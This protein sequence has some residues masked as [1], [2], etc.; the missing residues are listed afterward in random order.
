[1]TTPKHKSRA[2]RAVQKLKYELYIHI[3]TPQAENDNKNDY[4]QTHKE[5]SSSFKQMSS[6]VLHLFLFVCFFVFMDTLGH[7]THW[8]ASG[9]VNIKIIT[10][11]DLFAF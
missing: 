5:L 8:P 3:E 4:K 7:L 2:G 1:M 11:Y 6:L 10:A 9:G